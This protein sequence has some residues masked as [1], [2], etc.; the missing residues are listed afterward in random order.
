MPAN[1]DK[2]K[3][4]QHNVHTSRVKSSPL[5]LSI[6]HKEEEYQSESSLDSLSKHDSSV[7]EE[8]MLKDVHKIFKNDEYLSQVAEKIKIGGLYKKYFS[9]DSESKRIEDY[10]LRFVKGVK[11]R[12]DKRRAGHTM[13]IEKIMNINT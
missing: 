11:S 1:K 8:A 2:K 9:S 13:P 12:E 7:D 5:G 3:S 6:G 4:R 10:A